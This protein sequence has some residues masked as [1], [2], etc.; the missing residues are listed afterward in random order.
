MRLEPGPPR[1]AGGTVT[2][3]LA[4]AATPVR[5]LANDDHGAPV[6]QWIGLAVAVP[7]APET[8]AAAPMVEDRDRRSLRCR[9]VRPASRRLMGR[10]LRL[11]GAVWAADPAGQRTAADPRRRVDRLHARGLSA[12]SPGRARE[13]HG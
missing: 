12:R 9:P 11:P 10:S 6:G 7:L 5:A 8:A 2:Q 1:F 4:A 13:T 3:A